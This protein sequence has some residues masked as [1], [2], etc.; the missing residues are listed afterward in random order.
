MPNVYDHFAAGRDHKVVFAL[1]GTVS[2]RSV[3][4]ADI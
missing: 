4:E 2:L 3:E 1:H